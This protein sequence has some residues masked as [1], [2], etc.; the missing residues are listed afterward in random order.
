MR[1]RTQREKIYSTERLI[2]AI[3]LTVIINLTFIG[4]CIANIIAEY[5]QQD[6]TFRIYLF[7]SVR[8]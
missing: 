3:I 4:P 8:L 7:I 5:N 1:L 6:A 2:N